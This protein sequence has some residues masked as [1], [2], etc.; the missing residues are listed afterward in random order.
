MFLD[1]LFNTFLYHPGNGGGGG[2]S[3][4]GENEDGK[5]DNEKG[6]NNDEETITMTKAEY[7]AKLNQKFAEGA[8]KAAKGGDGNNPNNPQ[9][10]KPGENSSENKGNNN[11]EIVSIKNELEILKGEKLALKQGV[12]PD[13]AEDAVAILKGKGLEIS[14][15]NMKAIVEKHPEWKMSND[16]QGSGVAPLG[17]TGGK[18][19]PPAVNEQEQAAKM[20]GF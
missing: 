13:Y 15:A 10:T 16:T 19:N 4:T 2:A 1:F 9:N 3:G 20:F 11:D 7:E 14:E 8:R 18:S 6:G 12:K 5:E 17:S